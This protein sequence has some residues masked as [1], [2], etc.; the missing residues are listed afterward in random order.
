MSR[1]VNPSLLRL[2]V[3]NLHSNNS[4]MDTFN[5]E[6]KFL[7]FLFLHIQKRMNFLFEQYHKL[8][9][10]HLNKLKKK[11]SEFEKLKVKMNIV[12]VKL[13]GTLAI[14][15]RTLNLKKLLEKNP[16]MHSS[17]SK[18][19][20]NVYINLNTL[21]ET[22]FDWGLFEEYCTTEFFYLQNLIKNYQTYIPESSFIFQ[23]GLFSTCFT[24]METPFSTAKVHLGQLK[25]DFERVHSKKI[26]AAFKI[27]FIR[28]ND[29]SLSSLFAGVK[30]RITGRLDG[31]DRA[32]SRYE[33]QGRVALR[34]YA[35]DID[36]AS[37]LAV[38]KY[39]VLGIK[40]WIDHGISYSFSDYVEYQDLSSL[41][42][43]TKLN[44][45]KNKN[46]KKEK[47]N[48]KNLI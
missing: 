6:G 30:L 1:K 39:G 23:R 3:L 25:V 48:Y 10:I 41:F 29:T 12:E 37:D 17:S 34:T 43:I 46:K 42:Y 40:M 31:A 2:G 38:T 8:I 44:K 36:Y 21:T 15:N 9:E 14:H 27:T 4:F 20:S 19:E 35:S 22:V 18:L 13:H 33:E 47:I 16:F 24:L 26:K 32:R 11:R 45:N 28:M 5:Y 7:Y